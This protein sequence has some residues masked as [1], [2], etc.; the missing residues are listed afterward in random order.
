MSEQENKQTIKST[1]EV[2]SVKKLIDLNGSKVNFYSEFIIDSKNPKKNFLVAVL[3]QDDLDNGTLTFESS[4][5]GQFA[6]SI[7]YQN[8][9]LKNHFIAVKR[10]PS[11]NSKEA[12]VCDVIRVLEKLPILEQSPLNS[13]TTIEEQDTIEQD[14]P[15][16]QKEQ[17]VNEKNIT[18]EQLK[19]LLNKNEGFM[20]YTS[21]SF[22]IGVICFIIFF[23]LLFQKSKK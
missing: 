23:V 17:N 8:N 9:V 3:D 19:L 1:I 11:D 4:D 14:E 18:E 7:I 5:N 22:I 6:R 20:N 21:P 2:E 12:L 16:I 10:L 13:L 15:D